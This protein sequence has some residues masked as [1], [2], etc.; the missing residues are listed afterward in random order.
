MKNIL[1]EY[2]GG[3][4]DGCVWEWNYC[5]VDKQGKFHDIVSSGYAGIDHKEQLITRM[6]NTLETLGESFHVYN[7][8][9]PDDLKEFAKNS[10]VH[11]V[12]GVAQWID[13]NQPNISDNH[14]PLICS[15]CG[16]DVDSEDIEFT[17]D[18]Y[19]GDGGIG[20]QFN[21]LL[22]HDCNS[23]Y[24][25][26]YCGD[27]YGEDY[28]NFN[29][30]GYCEYCAEAEIERETRREYEAKKAD[31]EKWVAWTKAVYI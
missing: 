12:L 21:S 11:G 19:Q 16:A 23:M 30:E 28:E 22:C 9:N 6:T 27:Y 13:K 25:C 1:I 18:D 26:G 29:D 2:Q 15:C 10:N 8:S 4:Y 31:Y 14:I 7:F 5:L 17:P 24:S 3:G 20:I